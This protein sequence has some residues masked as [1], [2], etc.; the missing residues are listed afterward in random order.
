MSTPVAIMTSRMKPLPRRH[1]IAHLR[2]LIRLQSAGSARRH[3]LA[4][5][6]RAEMLARPDKEDRAV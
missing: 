1:R 5:L 4:A 3:E 6:L 2:A